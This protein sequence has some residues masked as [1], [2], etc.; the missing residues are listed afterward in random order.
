[1]KQQHWL[2][3]SDQSHQLKVN[4]WLPTEKPKAVIQLVH[5]MVE[6]IDRYDSFA[7]FLNA[8]GYAVIGHDHLGHG[9][10][11]DNVGEYGYFAEQKGY[12]YLITD[13]KRIEEQWRTKFPEVPYFL[14]GHSMG[15]LVVRDVLIEYPT[16]RLQGAI[17]MGTAYES[18]LKMN[19][20]LLVSRA[21]IRFRGKRYRSTFL[22][23][24]AF[25]GFNRHIHSARTSKDWLSR[26]EDQ[27]DAYIQDPKNQFTFTT[28][29]YQDLFYLTKEASSPKKLKQIDSR[30]PLLVISGEEDPVGRYGKG[31][32][33]C[34]QQLAKNGNPVTLE[35]MAEGRH[36]LLNEQN[37]KTV[38]QLL[39]NWL[40]KYEKTSTD[41][42]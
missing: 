16:E 33:A 32:I 28:Q 26:D 19:V 9:D 13:V 23:N 8:Q 12:R 15:S 39:V 2:T 5:G 7:K 18:L 40:R 1:M 25:N 38:Y 6:H 31:V 37:A 29:A 42:K 20:A 11:I 14:L 4:Y 17:M 41:R 27:V 3:S 35:L 30:L 36:E 10:S 21:F 22:D 34:A 24:L